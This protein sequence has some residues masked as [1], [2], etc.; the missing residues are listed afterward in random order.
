MQVV[1]KIFC[2]ERTNIEEFSAVAMFRS[3]NDIGYDDYSHRDPVLHRTAIYSNAECS[4]T[5]CA[6]NRQAL[7][8]LNTSIALPA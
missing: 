2:S 8:P 7:W 5:I 6:D 3:V 1:S 4:A